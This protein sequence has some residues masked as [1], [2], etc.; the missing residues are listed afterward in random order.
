MTHTNFLFSVNIP[1]ILSYPQLILSFQ[2]LFSELV[3]WICEKVCIV[4]TM[5]CFC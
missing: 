1:D 5:K 3:Q 4:A 2:P